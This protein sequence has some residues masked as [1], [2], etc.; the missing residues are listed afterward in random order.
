VLWASGVLFDLVRLA[1][2]APGA[3]GLFIGRAARQRRPVEAVVSVNRAFGHR[4]PDG[5][6]AVPEAHGPKR[7]LPLMSDFGPYIVREPEQDFCALR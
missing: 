4:G 6:G 1:V 5:L 7:T 3:V 2:L